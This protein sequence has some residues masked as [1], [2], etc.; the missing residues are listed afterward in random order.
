[1]KLYSKWYENPLCLKIQKDKYRHDGET[2]VFDMINRIKNSI[3]DKEVSDAVGTLIEQGSLSFGGR[4][5]YGAGSKGKFNATTSNCYI[6]P[7]PEDSVE[8]IMKI[9]TEMTTVFKSGGGVGVDIS[10][11]RPNGAITHN[12]ARISTGA[13]SFMNIYNAIGETMGFHGRRGATLIGL[14]CSHPDIE[15]FINIRKTKSLSAM[16]IS[17]KVTNEFLDAVKNDLEYVLHF[18]VDATGEDINKPIKAKKIWDELCEMAWDYGD[19]GLLYMDNI[20]SNNFQSNNPKFKIEICNPCV[21]GTTPILTDEGYFHIKDLVGKEVNI[22]NGMQWSTVKPRITGHDQK[23]KR[24]T[25]SNGMSLDCTWYHKWIMTDGSRKEAQDLS[26]GESLSK[27]SYPVLDIGTNSLDAKEAYTH[28]F[29]SGDGTV[30]LNE[31]ALYDSKRELVPYMLISELRETP[32]NPNRLT[33][34][35]YSEKLR[36]NKT[37]V[38]STQYDVNTRLN[39][40]AGLID[41]D[42]TLNDPSGSVTISSINKDFLKNVQLMLTTLG[43]HS[44]VTLMRS[45]GIKS[46]PANNGTGEYKDYYCQDCYRVIISGFNMFK[47][48]QLGLKLFR[49]NIDNIK[50]NRDASKFVTIV[51]IEDIPDEETVYCVNEPFNHSVVFN[52]IMTANCS[53]YT[54]PAGNSCNL[55]SLNLYNF[56]DNKFSNTAKLN[57]NRLY[58]AVKT[59]IKALDNILDYGYD[60]QPLQIF[61]DN[62]DQWRSIGLGFF[63]LADAMIALKIKYDSPEGVNFARYVAFIMQASAMAASIEYAKEKGCFK[64]CNKTALLHNDLVN[65]VINDANNKF[66]GFNIPEPLIDDISH[67][68]RNIKKYGMRNS[69]LLSIAPTGTISLMANEASSGIEP[70]FKVFMKRTSHGMEDKKIFFN[71]V[72]HSVAQLISYNNY[73]S[74]IKINEDIENVTD[75]TLSSILTTVKQLYPFVIEAEELDPFMKINVQSAVQEYVDNAI[76]STINLKESATIDDVSKIFLSSG[77]AGLKGITVFRENCKRLSILTGISDKKKEEEKPKKSI[78]N[79]RNKCTVEYIKNINNYLKENNQSLHDKKNKIKLNLD[80]TEDDDILLKKELLEADK[81]YNNDY[82]IIE[83]EV[84]VETVGNDGNDNDAEDIGLNN[85]IYMNYSYISGVIIDKAFAINGT[86]Y[87]NENTKTIQTSHENN[88][89][90]SGVVVNIK[91][92][93]LEPINKE[94]N[95]NKYINNYTIDISVPVNK[96]GSKKH[97]NTK[98]ECRI[99]DN[100]F[101]FKCNEPSI[102][103]VVLKVYDLV[104]LNKNNETNSC[105]KSTCDACSNKCYGEK[106]H[107]TPVII[108][109]SDFQYQNKMD[110][111]LPIPAAEMHKDSN[112]KE[113]GLEGKTYIRHSACVPRMYIS[114][115]HDKNN[116]IFEVFL[117]KALDGGCT[118][119]IATITNLVSLSLRSGIKVEKIVEKLKQNICSA[120]AKRRIDKKDNDISLSCGYALATALESEY[121]RLKSINRDIPQNSIKKEKV[122]IPDE[123]SKPEKNENNTKSNNSLDVIDMGGGKCPDCGNLT[124][125]PDGKC[126]TCKYCGWS[127][128]E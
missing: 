23:M 109:D 56:I 122:D 91:R 52:G 19:P 34:K 13:V 58:F 14:D 74:S 83:K 84:V 21:T 60:L 127:K 46:M 100:K 99:I 66:K 11:L 1:M 98:L 9:G 103:A 76:S 126:V 43:V 116:N 121:K 40:L 3:A 67:F 18:H 97:I 53:E 12:A 81:K 44:S 62:I 8:D 25:L 92:I 24:I 88:E 105:S 94:S 113:D 49:I 30:G 110:Y 65:K 120:C 36:Y 55:G 17:V 123:I 59:S 39:W 115:N 78:N 71:V 106:E 26:V 125:F 2:S 117:T 41:S 28:G 38:P 6:M 54:G 57:T 75:E 68:K 20:N 51:S 45:S 5:N 35:I 77:E 22:W 15:D 95:S 32:S 37:W 93:N 86:K 80:N 82:S 72:A 107:P 111:L 7:H 69:Q 29:Y 119:N 90:I 87:Y 4:I 102:K 104:K 50:P 31:I 10:H 16:N 27:W 128:C 108:D 61:K 47:L 112:G 42:G 48:L 118:A 33:A 64:L 101:L 85:T 63:G 70:I 114:I 73:N 124:I 89:I 96:S 79:E